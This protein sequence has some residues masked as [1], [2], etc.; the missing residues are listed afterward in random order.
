MNVLS[1]CVRSSLMNWTEPN[2][3]ELN[4]I[5]LESHRFVPLAVQSMAALI[6]CTWTALICIIILS[7]IFRSISLLKRARCDCVCNALIFFCLLL[8]I[9]CL[10]A[11][12][13]FFVFVHFLI[14]GFH[15]FFRLES[16]FFFSC[17][18]GRRV[19]CHTTSKE[20]SQVPCDNS[21]KTQLYLNHR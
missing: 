15:I 1:I 17:V 19:L 16:F 9:N 14:F 20:S 7:A 13:S 3:S 6:G 5:G 11:N 12:A 18:F 21:E 4:W 2:R 8:H 10:L